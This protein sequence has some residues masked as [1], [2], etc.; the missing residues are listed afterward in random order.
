M[1]LTIPGKVISVDKGIA[2]VKS[3]RETAQIDLGLVFDA[4]P[5]DWI[6]YATNRAVKRISEDDAK[7]IIALL[8]D[9]YH[10][11]DVSALPLKF[12]KIIYK[13]RSGDSA[14]SKEEIL[15]LLSLKGRANL[16]TL[17]AE[18]N[19]L[20]KDKIEDFICIH[21]IIEFSNY[22]K[23]DCLYCGIRKSH[24]NHR[25]RMQP[26]E[27]VEVAKIAV[28]DDGYKLLVLQSGEDD[29]YS[30][31]MLIDLV[32]EI[33]SK[34]R[35]FVFLSVGE[36]SFDFYKKAYQAGATGALIRFESGNADL[37]ARLRPGHKL[38]DRLNLIKEMR[39]LGYYVATGSLFGVPG[40][41]LEDLASDLLLLKGLDVPMVSSGPYI[42]AK[43]T[44]LQ[45]S[46]SEFPISKQFPKTPTGQFQ[47]ISDKVLLELTLKYI[48]IA[49]F[50]MPESKI[51]VTTALETL[52]PEGR[53]RGLLAGANSL[54]FNLT[55]DKYSKDYQIY[56]NKYR[57]REKVWQKYGLFKDEESWEMLEE[58]MRILP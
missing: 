57:E 50:L 19:F 37:Y 21:G 5:G 27:I 6:L 10:P 44:P 31:Q 17:Y 1:C 7:E 32:R 24:A 55:P 3:T 47:N 36:R 45:I 42:G 34:M 33:K 35:V 38:A 2:T 20:R 29:F 12:K 51:P 49:R 58:R 18:A 53:H 28:E 30:D 43:G 54:M 41:T 25:F 8:E 13:V 23:N 4:Q 16:E 46:K 9:N 39:D 52:N 22:C 11:V 26:H 48:A 14:L 40:Q 15:Y 56:D